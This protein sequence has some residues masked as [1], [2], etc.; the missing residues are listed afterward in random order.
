MTSEVPPMPDETAPRPCA[1]APLAGVRIVDVSMLGP[2]ALTTHLADLGADVIKV[3]PPGGEYVRK[4]VWPFIEGVSLLHWHISRGKRSV[5]LDLRTEA[6]LEVFRDLVRGA[7]AVV[8]AM[9]PGALDRRGLGFAALSELNPRL[10]MRSISG[11][12]A[13]GP[14]RD[15]P[16]HGIAYDTWAGVVTPAVDANG[17]T[18]LPEHASIG[19]HA[20]P[21]YGAL[22][23]VAAILA[24]R[25]T[26][27]GSH[28]EVGQA[29]AAAAMDWLRSETYRAYERPEDEV[30]GNPVDDYE[31]RT[32][33]TG[34]MADGVRYQVY[35]SADGH[36]LF[37]ASERKFWK[38]FC[39]GVGRM[40]LYDRRPG[41]EFADH[42]RG[43]LATRAE[44]TEIFATRTTAE[45]IWF[46]GEHDTTIAPVNTPKSI[47]ED[48]QFADRLPWL[49]AETFGID[50]LPFPV[51]FDGSNPQPRGRAPKPGE[52]AAEVLAGVLGYDEEKVAEL[53]AAGAFGR[54]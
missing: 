51:R 32:P 17:F 46:A 18:Y 33:G 2:G 34:G 6:G 49:P 47:I 44:L 29:D 11:Y 30:S 16:S 13:S 38:N 20:G 25:E 22:G 14:Y 23:L 27:R 31:R 4:M 10:V 3:E 43:D 21:L 28:V 19:I 42:A 39:A 50:E 8:E 48:P 53:R 36:V 35:R 54:A 41:A 7:D 9:R 26:G 45:W 37:M 1:T 15:L 5:E 52:H 40:D 24:A 12:G